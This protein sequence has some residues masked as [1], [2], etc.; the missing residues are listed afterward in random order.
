MAPETAK[1]NPQLER[2]MNEYRELARTARE[3]KSPA[4]VRAA[5]DQYFG[6][7]PSAATVKCEPVSAGGVKA[8]WISATNANRDRVILYVHGGGYAAGSIASH[9]ELV[10]RLSKAAEARCLSVDYRLAP[11]HPFPAAVE[12]ATAAYRW[13]LENQHCRPERIAIA[14]D[15]AGGGL[16]VATLVALRDGRTPLPAAAACISP[17]VDLEVTGG[18]ADSNAELDPLVSRE[19]LQMFT[20]M[21]LGDRDPRT[22]LASPLYADL[23]GL[24]P[25]LIQVGS[26]E[27]LLDD[28]RRLTE[29]ARA[30]GVTA[31]LEVWPDMPHVWH[32]CAPVLDDGQRAIER[33]GAF[34]R[35]RT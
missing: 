25:M 21:Y 34:V 30:A 5:L 29:R 28:A 35:Q 6:A 32:W 18:T 9:R 19:V 13:L 11:E 24:P 20:Q 1:N 12:D 23:R 7:F 15:S 3:A 31:E 33:I 27:T 10:A 8:E 16:A 2:V 26:G 4:E 14:G 17:W 22:P